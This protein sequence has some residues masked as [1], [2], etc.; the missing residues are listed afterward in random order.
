MKLY[1]LKPGD[2]C[3]DGDNQKWEFVEEISKG[4]L[5]FFDPISCRTDY[6]DSNGRSQGF[7]HTRLQ[8]STKLDLSEYPVGTQ[9]QDRTGKTWTLKEYNPEQ[10]SYPV[11]LSS[12]GKTDSWT[13]GGWSFLSLAPCPRDIVAV[14]PSV[15][16]I[17]DKIEEPLNLANHP[18]GTVFEAR[19]GDR[20]VLK[21]HSGNSTFPCVATREKDNLTETFT[22]AG[23]VWLTRKTEDDLIKAI[24]LPDALDLVAQ[25]QKLTKQLKEILS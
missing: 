9:F 15:Q 8:P 1:N 4:V 22:F 12:R 7:Q 18:R 6:F 17:I 2:V 14:V 10:P 13:R 16:E 23:T 5:V 3:F 21:S 11:F 20:W 24:R 25:I 19:N